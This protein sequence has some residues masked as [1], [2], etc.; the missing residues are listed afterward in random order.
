MPSFGEAIKVPPPLSELAENALWEI[1]T[2]GQVSH[3]PEFLILRAASIAENYV[4]NLLEFLTAKYR[5]GESAFQIA[6]EKLTNEKMHQGWQSR[7]EWLRGSFEISIDG[8]SEEQD[9]T[10]LVQ[11]RNAV[12]HGSGGLTRMQ[13]NRLTEQLEIERS[14]GTRFQVRTD[15][16]RIRPTHQTGLSALRV[17]TEYIRKLD[18][19]AADTVREHHLM[20]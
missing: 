11:L 12:A 7:R 19:E 17:S 13:R 18:S 9:F 4:D 5:H 14:L 6:V 2:L 3:P 15:G 8:S 16:Y 1:A 20:H 10:L